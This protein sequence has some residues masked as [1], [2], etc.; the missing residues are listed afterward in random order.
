[1]SLEALLQSADATVDELVELH[2]DLV[3]FPTVNS[4]VM[5]TGNETPCAEYL[6]SLLR[7]ERVE[8][9]VL[10]D[11]PTRG[12]LTASLGQGRPRLLWMAHLDVVPPGDETDWTHPPFAAALVDGWVYGRGS[13]DCKGLAAPM[14]HALRLLARAG[15]S[16][17]GQVKLVCGADEETGGRYGF[18]YLAREHP[19]CLAAELAI[20]EG[21][22]SPLADGGGPLFLAAPGEKGR[23]EAVVTLH[24]RSEHASMP[25]LADNPLP[26]LAE[27]LARLES[28]QAEVYLTDAARV[29]LEQLG[30]APQA[31]LA[32][33]ATTLA[34]PALPVADAARLRALTQMTCTPTM[35]AGGIKSN[36]IPNRVEL[37]LDI[38]ALPHQDPGHAEAELR[39]LLAGIAGLEMRLEPTALPSATPWSP[40]LRAVL[41]RA[42]HAAGVAGARVAP[43][44]CSGFTDARLVRPL[45]V[46]V[47]GFAPLPP[48]TEVGRCGCHNV[49]EQFPVAALW[50]RT[51][52]LLALA[53]NFCADGG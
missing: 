17:T 51:R 47:V 33:L 7:A 48:E 43:T 6:A 14:V 12:N 9:A 45:G 53:W 15:W 2:R 21:G 49:D 25:W 24:G 39:A 19:E 35:V 18:G 27:V 10:A 1:M 5:P 44:L 8:A 36:A 40:A 38:R 34:N 26:R 3:R 11:E 4:G 41:E 20:N 50:Y 29:L 22:G 42:L 52:F 16:N 23:Y 31:G 30:A 13:N 37:R 32:E 28:Y 46:P